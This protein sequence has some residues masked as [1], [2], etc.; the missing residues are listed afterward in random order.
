MSLT[1]YTPMDMHQHDRATM[2]EFVLRGELTGHRVVDLEHAWDTAKSI[3]AGKELVV[4]IA[5]IVRA[6]PAGVEL[7]CRMRESGARLAA[8]RG[9]VQGPRA[10]WW[11]VWFRWAGPVTRPAK[12]RLEVLQHELDVACARRAFEKHKRGSNGAVGGIQDWRIRQ[13][14]EVGA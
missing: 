9:S 14:D 6:D 11:R 8:A 5:G 12:P 4:D 3:L 1:G 7:L 2:F 13:V 10:R